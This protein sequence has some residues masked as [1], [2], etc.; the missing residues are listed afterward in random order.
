MQRNIP[1]PKRSYPH[2]EVLPVPNRPIIVLVTVCTKDRCP[3]LADP[4]VHEVL[5]SVWRAANAWFVGRYVLLPDHLHLF[6]SPNN[7]TIPLGNWVRFWKAQ[8]SRRHHNP[9]HRW[10][11]GYW[12]RTLRSNENYDAQWEYVRHNPVRHG[13][14][15]RPEDWPYQGELFPL[16]W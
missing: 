2:H 8:F 12:D 6:A 5:V 7:E 16:L 4:Q 1:L 13:L 11:M 14:V 3:W 9:E 10:Q 15:Q